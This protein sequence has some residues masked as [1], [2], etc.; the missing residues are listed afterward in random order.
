MGTVRMRSLRLLWEVIPAD[1]SVIEDIEDIQGTAI[2]CN[3][4]IEDME[5]GN[6]L[7]LAD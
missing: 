7:T 6:F 1:A 4:L 2:I 3:N 5:S